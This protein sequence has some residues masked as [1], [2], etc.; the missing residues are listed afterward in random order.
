MRATLGNPLN[1]VIWLRDDL[2]A[3]GYR[4]KAGDVIS[5]GSFSPL[6]PPKAGQTITVTYDGL[7][8]PAS[9]RVKF[10]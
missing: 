6:T 10:Q 8:K 7:V 1:V 3:A 5:V 9:V 2:K 4:L